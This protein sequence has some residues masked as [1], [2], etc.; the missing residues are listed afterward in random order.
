MYGYAKASKFTLVEKLDASIDP[1]GNL[2]K[3]ANQTT[4]HRTR[5]WSNVRTIYNT[6]WL[7]TYLLQIQ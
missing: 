4:K 1:F 3:Y 2:V 7:L 5:Q 6:Q